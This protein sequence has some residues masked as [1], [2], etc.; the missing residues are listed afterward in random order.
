MGYHTF[1]G[2]IWAMGIICAE[3]L[4][5]E[6]RAPL[7]WHDADASTLDGRKAWQAAAVEFSQTLEATLGKGPLVL[8]TLG[9]DFTIRCC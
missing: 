9:L 4:H 7:V 3:L 8:G 1:Q 2:D 5:E 6:P